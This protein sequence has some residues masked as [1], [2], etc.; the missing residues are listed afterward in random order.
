MLFAGRNQTVAFLSLFERKGLSSMGD[1]Q[2]ELVPHPFS[3]E[4]A[5]LKV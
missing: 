3:S 4:K 5:T 1:L 2:K